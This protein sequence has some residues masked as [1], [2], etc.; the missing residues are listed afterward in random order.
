M[1]G[2]SNS[3]NDANIIPPS[4]KTTAEAQYTIHS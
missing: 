1:V 4:R 3:K 2:I